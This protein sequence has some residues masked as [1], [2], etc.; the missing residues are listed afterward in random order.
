MDGYAWVA[1]D[2]VPRRC[3]KNLARLLTNTLPLGEVSA[4]LRDRRR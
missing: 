3:A 1:F 2:E 4:R